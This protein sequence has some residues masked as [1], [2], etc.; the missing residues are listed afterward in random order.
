M[1]LA[2]NKI[3]PAKV[4][5]YYRPVMA[6]NQGREKRRSHRTGGKTQRVAAV[7]NG[8]VIAR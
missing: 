1:T 4:L 2:G 3:G 7:V 8:N 6:S 5:S